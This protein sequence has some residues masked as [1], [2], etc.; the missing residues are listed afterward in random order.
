MK[1]AKKDNLDFLEGSAAPAISSDEVMVLI[2]NLEATIGKIEAAEKKLDGLKQVRDHLAREV[3]P[4]YLD[5]HGISELTL[6][7]G[8]KVSVKEDLFCRLPADPFERDTALTW[9]EAHGGEA[10]IKDVVE[11]SDP[12]ETLLD[13]LSNNHVAYSRS[14]DVHPQ[15][16]KAFFREGT[17]QKKGSVALFAFEDVPKQFGLFVKREVKLN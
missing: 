4:A 5:Q 12:T 2:N 10:L 13:T 3:I 9:L 11:V 6:A 16:L 8:K 1:R 14:R 17:G 15:T 7:S